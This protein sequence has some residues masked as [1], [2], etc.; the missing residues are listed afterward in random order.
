METGHGRMEDAHV[1]RCGQFRVATV[2]RARPP[3]GRG[4]ARPGRRIWT[5][6]LRLS[7]CTVTS[8]C[9]A[10]HGG[11][12]PGGRCASAPREPRGEP[13][14]LGRSCGGA[15]AAVVRLGT[16]GRAE[17]LPRSHSFSPALCIAQGV[18]G[19]TGLR[20]IGRQSHKQSQYRGPGKGCLTYR[21]TLV[22]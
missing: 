16:R 19:G 1:C 10:G 18:L 12:G 9:V 3:G 15:R 13:A 6:C 8:G 17:A 14:G 21:K 11:M 7:G 5:Q 2:E 20:R 22:S 4:R